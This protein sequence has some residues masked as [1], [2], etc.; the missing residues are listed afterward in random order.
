M[1]KLVMINTSRNRMNRKAATSRNLTSG[2]SAASSSTTV[3]A[4]RKRSTRGPN[5]SSDFSSTTVTGATLRLTDEST[6]TSFF[7]ATGTDD[8][9]VGDG[10]TVAARFLSALTDGTGSTSLSGGSSKEAGGATAGAE[11]G[12]GISGAAAT[13]P[14]GRTISRPH[15]GQYRARERTDAPHERHRREI[16]GSFNISDR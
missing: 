7:S 4:C 14:D 1:I 12:E 9:D 6:T 15:C 16:S 11:T 2:S 5:L 10:G 13:S 3:E 8:N